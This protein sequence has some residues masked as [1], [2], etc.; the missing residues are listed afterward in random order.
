MVQKA[1]PQGDKYHYGNFKQKRIYTYLQALVMSFYSVN[2]YVDVRHRWKGLGMLYCLLLMAII[3]LPW[4]VYLANKGDGFYQEV[5]LPSLSKIPVLNIQNGELLYSPKK[6]FI[7]NHPK[8]KKPLIIIDTSGEI[9]ELPNKLYP[10]ATVLFTR[11]AMIT[12]YGKSPT[13]VE[14]YGTDINGEIDSETLKPFFEHL[15]SVFLM[16]IYP[17]LTTLIFGL[18]YS[19]LAVL[20]FVMKMFSKI[21]MKYDI[22][23]KEALRLSV[24]SSTPMITTFVTT[25]A[26][27]VEMESFRWM[28]F[29]IYWLYFIFAIRSN[30]Y[31]ARHPLVI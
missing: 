17:N 21:L 10:D 28:F 16:M 13:N 31:A 19:M 29:V 11:Y 26:T 4:A 22:T 8:T 3:T 9:T 27:G 24:V 12:K 1:L 14:R 15:R 23:Y 7:I 30:K 5:F 2:I 25:Y 6:R 18:Y 20:A